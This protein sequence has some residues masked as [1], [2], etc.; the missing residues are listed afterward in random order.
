MPLRNHFNLLSE[1]WLASG[2]SQLVG[3]AGN[4]TYE[5]AGRLL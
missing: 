3:L 5:L 2:G 1:S 4:F